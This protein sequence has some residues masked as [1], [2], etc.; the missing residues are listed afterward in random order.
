MLSL[1][2]ESN[3]S[4]KLMST[5]EFYFTDVPCN[6]TK[7]MKGN[8]YTVLINSTRNMLREKWEVS[9]WQ[10]WWQINS[11]NISFQSLSL[12]LWTGNYLRYFLL[13]SHLT[14]LTF[15]QEMYDQKTYTLIHKHQNSKWWDFIDAQVSAYEFFFY[16][17]VSLCTL[18]VTF[19][20]QMRDKSGWWNPVLDPS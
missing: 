18:T 15:F 12:I 10:Y 14:W 20:L 3:Y 2:L 17:H 19:Q 11:P 8:I 1:M 13:C 6:M 4:C 7:S 5:F 16:M 9:V